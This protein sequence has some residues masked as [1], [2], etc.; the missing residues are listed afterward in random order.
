MKKLLALL[1]ALTGFGLAACDRN[2]DPGNEEPGEWQT[3]YG[4]RVAV[5]QGNGAESLEAAAAYSREVTEET[6]GQC[7]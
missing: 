5:Y 4:P 2:E 7:D 1:L 6:D 3:Y